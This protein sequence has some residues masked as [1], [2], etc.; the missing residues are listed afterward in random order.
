MTEKD[1]MLEGEWYNANDKEQLEKERLKAKE[2]CFDLNHTRPSDSKKIEDIITQLFTYH[3]TNLELLPPFYVDYGSNIFLGK[4]VFI[5]HGSYF[6]DAN[7]IIVG[8]N[9]FIGPNVGL[10]TAKHPLTHVQ[11]NRGLEQALPI[12]I[13]SNVWIGANVSVLPGVTI[14]SGAVISAGSVVTRD[15]PKNAIVAGIPA[16]IIKSIHENDDTIF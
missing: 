10:Y 1:K 14:E 2:L 8:D 5:N 11:R 7:R 9:V 12:K 15:V 4:N 16:K 6:M 3:P 13:G